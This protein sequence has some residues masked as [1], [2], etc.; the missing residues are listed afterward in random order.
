VASSTVPATTVQSGN[1][2]LTL[3]SLVQPHRLPR[4][5]KAPIAV[6]LSGHL[7]TVDGGVP[8]Q[9]RG[10][11]V[12]VNR[13]GSI[14]PRGVPVCPIAR[15]QPS[16]TE[17][18][19]SRCGPAVVGS[20]QFWAHI[21][22]PGQDPYPTHGRLLIFNG[23]RHGHPAILAHIYTENPF[24]TSF[25]IPFAIEHIS[26]GAYGTRL[27]ADLPRALGEWGYVDRIKLTLRRRFRWQGRIR[28]YF[29]ANCPAPPGTRA[30]DFQLAR[31]DFEFG[32]SKFSLSVSKSCGVKG[33]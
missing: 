28:S 19:V 17:L 7:Q 21:V 20:G 18:A 22:L 1:L 27:T 30:A 15:I 2:Q 29:S 5:E 9:L 25:V 8:P 26:K 31:A 32:Q 12:F 11:T 33:R 3:L 14:D 6:F 13:H 10:F 24:A 23:W 16:T 4:L